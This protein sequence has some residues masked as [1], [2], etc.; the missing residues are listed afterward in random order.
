MTISFKK[1]IFSNDI[2][3]K[4]VDPS[5]STIK[6]VNSGESFNT[7]NN[8]TISIQI[9]RTN[10]TSGKIRIYDWILNLGA[11]AKP[12]VE[13]N[14]SYLYAETVLAGNSLKKDIS[15]ENENGDWIKLKR[16]ETGVVL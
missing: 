2:N 13:R 11:T 15:F 10:S 5:G 9:L 4:V 3:V 16:F 6:Y 8:E 1:E 14:P 12:F 7:G